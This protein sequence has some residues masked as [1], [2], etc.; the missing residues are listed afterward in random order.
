MIGEHMTDVAVNSRLLGLKDVNVHVEDTGGDGRAVI[1]IHGWPLSGASWSEQI[2]ALR[3]AGLRVITYDRRGFGQSDKPS[4][5]YDYD[6]FAEDLNGLIE[7]LNVSNI[8]LVGF[9]MGGGEVA[10]YIAKYG[11][12]RLHSVVFA[13]A[14]PPMLMNTPDNPDGP[15]HKD[16]AEKM[17]AGLTQDD[18]AFYDGFLSQF[19]SANGDGDLLVTEQQKQAAMTLAE[20][21]DKDAALASMS[22]F[23]TTDFRDDL[24]KITI[25]TLI[26][27][28][29]AD[30]IVPFE[31]SGKRTHQAVPHSELHVVNGGP[32][33]INVSH[34][35]EF[36]D[37]LTAFL[38]K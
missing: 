23:A 22:A 14:I 5:G 36:N 8:S 1:L 35:Q 2:A 33:G 11:E 34:A 26:I 31:G 37:A 13:A 12:S 16:L 10:R 9:S 7:D 18:M 27:H 4:T 19:F 6:T 25:P 17:S 21:A 3:G 29:D 32:H 24:T 38:A 28:G 15:L 30:G 20:Q